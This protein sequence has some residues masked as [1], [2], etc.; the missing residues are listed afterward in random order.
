MYFNDFVI[1]LVSSKSCFG[2]IRGES[3]TR[4]MLRSTAEL[5]IQH[6]SVREV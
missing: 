1:L 5:P 4:M 2:Y 3:K 6:S